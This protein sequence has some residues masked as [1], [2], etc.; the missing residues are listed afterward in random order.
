MSFL[1]GRLEIEPEGSRTRTKG[2]AILA[3]LAATLLT[4]QAFA[5]GQCGMSSAR[6]A[7]DV[8]G[9][10]SELMVTALSCN[11][12]DRYNAFIEKFRPDLTAQEV[13]LNGYFRATY[14]RGAQTAHDDYITQLAN[15]QSERG[16]K[17]G[18]AF[19][20]Q[21]VSMF[22]EVAV[23]DN[24]SDLGGYA[25]AKDIVQPASYETCAA[26]SSLDHPA[27]VRHIRAVTRSHKG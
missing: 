13:A 9:L 14:G 25:E 7:F 11:V 19:C 6:Q 18:V 26:P 27:R 2:R 20:Q 1:V 23:L 16:L 8:Q 22:D 4:S 3:G 10:K 12:Q 15:A 17:A 24:A 5:A 21:R